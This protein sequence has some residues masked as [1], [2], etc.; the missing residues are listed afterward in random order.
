MFIERSRA[1]D[2]TSSTRA[3]GT[4]RNA[5][6]VSVPRSLDRLGG[7]HARTRDL[8][9][10]LVAVHAAVRLGEQRLVGVAVVRE[11]RRAGTDDQRDV[12]IRLDLEL[13]VVHGLLQ[14][15]AFCFGFF[16]SAAGKH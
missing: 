8:A 12:E 5:T 16:A 13:H 15:A 1:R 6:T 11:D 14:L 4:V 2:E 3:S 10:A 7:A 9:L